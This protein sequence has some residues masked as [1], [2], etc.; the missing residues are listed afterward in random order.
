MRAE[1]SRFDDELSLQHLLDLSLEDG[2]AYIREHA[3]KLTNYV[4][5]SILLAEEADNQLFRNSSISLKL[6]ELLIFFGE[7]VRHDLSQALGLA[8]KGKALMSV[9][10]AQAALAIL[11]TAA[12]KFLRLGDERNWAKTRTDWM[13]TCAWLGHPEE[14]LQEAAHVREVFKRFGEDY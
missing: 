4:A 10:H 12:E 11:D 13:I 8:A 6:A 2:Q 5:I 9:G 3:H 7:T 1:S 14:A